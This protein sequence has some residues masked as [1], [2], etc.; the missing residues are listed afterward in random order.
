MGSIKFLTPHLGIEAPDSDVA[1]RIDFLVRE[2]GYFYWKSILAKPEDRKNLQSV[3][4]RVVKKAIEEIYRKCLFS[5]FAF[6]EAGHRERWDPEKIDWAKLD[7]VS[8]SDVDGYLPS[9]EI[10]GTQN[11]LDC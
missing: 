8:I 5:E 6:V 9:M 11:Q 4:L 1:R 7:E 3:F 2:T 10:L